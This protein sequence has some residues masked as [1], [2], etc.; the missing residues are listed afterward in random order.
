[1]CVTAANTIDDIA[2]SN[3]KHTSYSHQQNRA[4][5]NDRAIGAPSPRISPGLLSHAFQAIGI[6]FKRT[7]VRRQRADK[8]SCGGLAGSGNIEKKRSWPAITNYADE[9]QK[10]SRP[11]PPFSRIGQ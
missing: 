3:T 5:S 11:A 7:L 9:S 10:D 2:T 1:M 6:V 4:I 8:S